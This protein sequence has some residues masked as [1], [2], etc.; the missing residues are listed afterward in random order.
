MGNKDTGWMRK[1]WV[2]YLVPGK[3]FTLGATSFFP[4]PLGPKVI[5]AQKEQQWHQKE[6]TF[7]LQSQGR[8]RPR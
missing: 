4:S 2:S 6:T 5:R 1:G 3:G 8:Q 7:V